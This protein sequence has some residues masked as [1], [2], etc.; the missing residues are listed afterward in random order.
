V[1]RLRVGVSFGSFHIYAISANPEFRSA[2][3][4]VEVSV[5]E[6]EILEVTGVDS[7]KVVQGNSTL[8]GITVKALSPGVAH[9]FIKVTYIPTGGSDTIQAIV[10]VR[11]PAETAE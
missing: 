5:L 11:D 2:D 3:F 1:Y 10:I 8:G 6:P 9:V 7:E 4:Q